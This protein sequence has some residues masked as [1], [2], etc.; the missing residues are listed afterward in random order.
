MLTTVQY[1]LVH[2]LDF[3]VQDS[4]GPPWEE[5]PYSLWPV[6]RDDSQQLYFLIA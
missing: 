6:Q 1:A 3:F 4:F 2:S 5:A